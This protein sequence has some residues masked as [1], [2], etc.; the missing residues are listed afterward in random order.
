MQKRFKTT[1]IWENFAIILS[2]ISLWPTIY[3]SKIKKVDSETIWVKPY[4]ILLVV[5]LCV[6]LIIFVRRV[7]RISTAFRENRRR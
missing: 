3:L 2:I 6:L 1:E 4:K 7:S 5:I